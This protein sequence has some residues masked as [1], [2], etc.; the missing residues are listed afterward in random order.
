MNNNFPLKPLVAGVLLTVTPLGFAQERASNLVLEEVIV[1]ATKREQ[2]MQ[3]VAVAVTALSDEL[4]KEAQINSSEDLTFLV[5]SLNLQKGSNPRQTSFAIR[6]IGTQSFSSAAE[7][8]VSTMVD[9]VVMG[10]S[11]QS[12]MSLLDVQRVEV[13]RGPRAPCLARI[14]QRV[15]SISLPGTPLRNTAARSWAASSVM[16]NIA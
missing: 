13:L 3:D 14:P 11:G 4:I 8:S 6:G 12:F 9:G 1:T 10:R 7:P 2:S 15:W 16:K 5:P